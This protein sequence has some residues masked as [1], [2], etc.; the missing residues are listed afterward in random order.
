MPK[1]ASAAKR[2]PVGGGG[3]SCRAGRRSSV[4]RGG[5]CVRGP[6]R[7][8]QPPPK[9]P[10]DP[11][12][13]VPKP[14]PYPRS[15]RCRWGAGVPAGVR[16]LA[17]R[18][19]F[20]GPRYS[21]SK[22]RS[23]LQKLSCTISSRSGSVQPMSSSNCNTSLTGHQPS[24][25][26]LRPNSLVM[27]RSTFAK[28]LECGSS[29]CGRLPSSKGWLRSPLLMARP[30][31]RPLPPPPRTSRIISIRTARPLNR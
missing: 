15:P 18:I 13:P 9:P 8:P 16:L 4:R 29:D 22:R 12:P 26:A 1:G 2:P 28:V 31:P 27:W 23:V 11:Y 10:P 20:S 30:L 17:A 6:P 14:P 3:V 21:T 5:V 24:L 7:E 25:S 19:H